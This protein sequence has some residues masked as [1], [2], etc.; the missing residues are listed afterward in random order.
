MGRP[1]KRTIMGFRVILP[2]IY[3]LLVILLGIGMVS[4]AG[5]TPK[6]LDFLFYAL[7][8]P[9]YVLDLFV[10]RLQIP[11]LLNALL[12]LIAGL[13]MYTLLGVL[14]DRGLARYRQ[15]KP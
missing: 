4:G 3:I 6:S 11:A 15:N 9:C 5:H 12:C 14:I 13:A 7:I 2:G 8:P 1:A 10:P